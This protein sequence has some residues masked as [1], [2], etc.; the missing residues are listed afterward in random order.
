MTKERRICACR[1]WIEA[2]PKNDE[3]VAQAVGE[4][5]RT[6]EHGVWR[7]REQLAGNL[8]TPQRVELPL[9]FT[10]RRVV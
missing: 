3:E 5:Q 1:R 7:A 6:F 10:L 9:K 4:H 8:V 2:D